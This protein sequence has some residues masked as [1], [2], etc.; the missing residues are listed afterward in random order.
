MINRTAS[1]FVNQLLN[2]KDN[3][4]IRIKDISMKMAII[5]ELISLTEEKAIEIDMS[6]SKDGDTGR[7]RSLAQRGYM[8]AIQKQI[9][10]TVDVNS[11]QEILKDINSWKDERNQLIHALL[12]K[13][14]G[15]SEEARKN[16]AKTG[17]ILSHSIDDALVKPFK[18][19]NRIR[20]KYNIQ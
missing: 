10:R 2:K 13:T 17:I 3:K 14:V 11:V 16:C 19:D 12:N 1:P 20:T 7:R 15:A 8:A 9:A 5:Q 4:T 18:K 6:I